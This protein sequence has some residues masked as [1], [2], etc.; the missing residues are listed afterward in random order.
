MEQNPYA[1]SNVPVRDDPSLPEGRPWP[2]WVI[3]IFVMFGAVSNAGFLVMLAMGK[4]P[5][6][7]Q[8]STYFSGFS[9]LD[10]SLSLISIVV[11]VAA[12]VALLRM[13][14]VAMPLMLAHLVI[15]LGLIAFQFTRPGYSEMINQSGGYVGM[16]VG[17]II[18]LSIAL[19]TYRLLRSGSLK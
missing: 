1:K 19:Y 4:F 14:R 7:P 2:V 6:T 13:R 9:T 15:S 18:T 10:Y 16:M 8:S 3:F 17:E 12:A 5:M 11:Y